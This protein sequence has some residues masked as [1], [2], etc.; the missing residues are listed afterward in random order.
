MGEDE[1]GGAAVTGSGGMPAAV[2]TAMEMDAGGMTQSAADRMAALTARATRAAC[3]MINIRDGRRL[4]LIG[5]YDVP[6]LFRRGEPVPM[7]S[8]LAGIV[9]SGGFPLVI[10]DVDADDRVP[11]DAPARSAGLRAYAGFPIL[12]PD[13]QIVGVC[14]V[15]DY[16][17]R[18]W[19]AEE[20]TAVDDGA[21]ACTAFVAAQY[22]REREHQQRLFLD[23][24]LDSLDTGVAACDAAG[25]LVVVNRSLRERLGTPNLQRSAEDW[26]ARLPITDTDGTPIPAEGTSLLRALRG[27]A[28]RGEENIL[29]LHGERRLFRINGHP[30][31]S[32]DGQRLGAV[33]VFHDI[34][35]ARRAEQLQQVLSRTKDDYLNLVGHELRTP[36]TVIDAYL[37]LMHAADPDE[38]VA[39]LL[40]M[41][42][43]ARR[44][45]IRLRRLVET[46]LD[47]SALDAGRS[48]LRPAD[49]NFSTVVTG[50]VHD[51]QAQ[52]AAKNITLTCDAAPI[53]PLH[54]DRHR[55][56]QMVTALLDNAVT[57]TPAGGAVTVRLT[58]TGH[59]ADLV[60]SDTGFGI[61]E[62]ELP[63]VFQRFFRGAITTELAIA[64][65]GLGLT[66]A[67][68]IVE[69]HHGTITAGPNPDGQR[70]TTI[71]VTLPQ[72]TGAPA[73]ASP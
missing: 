57:Y 68:L 61:P 40:P 22:A 59:L 1:R 39:D 65:T 23:T 12:D 2:M 17:T 55:L 67:Q 56:Y 30:I 43:A 73:G 53:T 27:E 24:L 46:L 72:T 9:I 54:A 29:H 19:S 64:G 49:I 50:A 35:A 7:F 48:P 5:G 70:G 33:A 18:A 58:S 14:A 63:H 34:T 62:H 44:G 26:A 6:A 20:L 21:Q 41:I 42:H 15:M 52:A 37:D 47:L 36:L 13:G 69:R 32:P 16:R 60:V 66:I 25:E 45:S 3:A 10:T 4:R 8:T 11:V 51:R 28:V 31:T 38:P 71:R